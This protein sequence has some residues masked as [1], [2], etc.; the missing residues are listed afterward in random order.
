M[1]HTALLLVTVGVQQ[2]FNCTPYIVDNQI[3][4]IMVGY[5]QTPHTD[6]QLPC[7]RRSCRGTY[8]LPPCVDL[9]AGRNAGPPVDIHTL[10][11]KDK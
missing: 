10:R 4:I 8:Q 5:I 9:S 6:I 7:P 1:T 11:D 3:K 2:K